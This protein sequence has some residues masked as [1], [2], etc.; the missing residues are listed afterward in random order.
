MKTVILD[1]IFGLRWIGQGDAMEWTDE[2][3]TIVCQL[4]AQQ[5]SKGNRPNTHLNSVGYDEVIQ[6]FRQITGIE[7]SK[8]QL[9]NKWDKLKPDFVAWQKL[10]R[11]QTG[12][13]WDQSRRVIVMDDEWWKK[14]KKMKKTSFYS[15]VGIVN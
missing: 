4:F 14:A 2:H 7:L 9:R 8:R 6:F 12:T 13:G 1:R 5:V 3:T 11:R 15:F 10:M